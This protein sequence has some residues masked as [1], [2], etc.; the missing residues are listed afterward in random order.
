[1]NRG[2]VRRF[3]Y[4]AAP[5]VVAASIALVAAAFV[6]SGAWRL[7]VPLDDAWIHMVYGLALRDEGALAYNAGVPATGCTSPLWAAFVAIAHVVVG[8]R[9]PSMEALV[10]VKCMGIA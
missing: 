2:L 10:V 1:M 3:A 8:A 7:G 6:G 4:V 9:G 5:E